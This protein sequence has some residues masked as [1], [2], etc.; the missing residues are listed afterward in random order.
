MVQKETKNRNW[1][2]ILTSFVAVMFVL[3]LFPG[4]AVADTPRERYPETKEPYRKMV[5][6][7]SETKE[8]YR[9]AGDKFKDAEDRFKDARQN[10]RTSKDKDSRD[11]LKVRTGEYLGTGIDKMIAHLEVLKNRVEGSENDVIPFDA[12]AN[13]DTHIAVLEEIRTKIQ[14]AE[15]AQEYV[16][17]ARDLK[18]QWDMIRLETRYAG[19]ILINSKIDTFMAKSE[20]VS[21]RTD[22]IIQKMESD[23]KDTAKLERAIEKFN[24]L[25]IEAKENQQDVHDLYALHDGF[26]AEGMVTDEKSARSFLDEA[27]RSQKETHKILKDAGKEVRE[28]F[29]EARGHITKR[30]IVSGNGTLEAD[31]DGMAVIRGD[32]TV[33]LSG[34]NG[35]MIVSNNSEVTTDGTGT[36]EELGNGN[37]KYEGF[38]SAT[39]SGDGIIVKI[40]GNGIELTATGTGSAILNGNGTY[41]TEGDFGTGGEWNEEE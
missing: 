19:G 3:S 2:N 35:T 5:E 22:A 23:G 11:K 10:F 37:V 14:N 9:D 6:K 29:K 33:T 32:V 39:V 16:D 8:Q 38:G 18:E 26:D 1:L 4:I 34:I 12:A 41:K 31:G 17:S 15:T 7:H 24:N 36:R 28:F 27:T 25:M 30:A 13:I 20:N 21:E 40:S